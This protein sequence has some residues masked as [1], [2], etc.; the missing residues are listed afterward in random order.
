M[1]APMAEPAT[2]TACPW[3]GGH[4]EPVPT[5]L[6]VAEFVH[7]DPHRDPR[8]LARNPAMCPDCHGVGSYEDWGIL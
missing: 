5:D 7:S 1:T 4:A 2:A 6:E 8:A 3:C